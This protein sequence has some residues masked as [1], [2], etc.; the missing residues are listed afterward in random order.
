MSG[1]MKSGRGAGYE[2]AVLIRGDGTVEAHGKAVV[3]SIEGKGS[4]K[5]E[6]VHMEAADIAAA[7]YGLAVAVDS[8]GLSPEVEQMIAGTQLEAVE[9]IKPD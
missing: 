2:K 3:V 9:V 8:L 4:M 7:T 6:F 5:V 1:K